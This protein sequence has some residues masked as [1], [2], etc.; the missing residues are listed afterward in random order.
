[1]HRATPACFISAPRSHRVIGGE[2]E[3]LQN[4]LPIVPRS[5]CVMI[6]QVD[7]PL[8]VVGEEAFQLL[9]NMLHVLQL[10]DASGQAH[11]PTGC[12]QRGSVSGASSRARHGD[13][14]MFRNIYIPHTKSAED[15]RL[16]HS[17]SEDS[18][19]GMGRFQNVTGVA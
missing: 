19:S 2:T 3:E 4:E 13:P 14:G 12:R 15:T 7:P 9:Q 17:L 10:R 5:T 1:M 18:V 11:D 8:G 6:V 16:N